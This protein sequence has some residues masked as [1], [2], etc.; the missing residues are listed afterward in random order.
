MYTSRE[1]SVGSRYLPFFPIPIQ[2]QRCLMPFLF[3]PCCP[4]QPKLSTPNQ[5]S[6]PLEIPART[7]KPLLSIQKRGCHHGPLL[8]GG[9]LALDFLLK[10]ADWR[11]PAFWILNTTLASGELD[12]A[13]NREGQRGEHRE[14]TKQQGLWTRGASA[15]SGSSLN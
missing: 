11:F 13:S 9:L 3:F 4:L 14:I 15:A 1:R 5:N 6:L 8:T 12:N 7:P 10:A 2:Q